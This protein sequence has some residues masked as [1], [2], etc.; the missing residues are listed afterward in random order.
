MPFFGSFG[1]GICCYA[2]ISCA[3]TAIFRKKTVKKTAKKREIA[4]SFSKGK[5]QIDEKKNFVNASDPA[6]GDIGIPDLGF[7]SRIRLRQRD[8]K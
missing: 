8:G 1:V 7:G 5:E 3:K 4:D 6:D 2:G